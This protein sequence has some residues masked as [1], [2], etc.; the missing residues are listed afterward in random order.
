M[1]QALAQAYQSGLMYATFNKQNYPTATGLAIV[2]LSQPP[3][4]NSFVEVPNAGAYAR[5]AV[6][7]T[8]SEWSYPYGIGSGIVFNNNQKSFAIATAPWG[9]VSG[10]A[11]ADCVGYGGG[12]T[13][14]GS[15]LFYGTVP[16]PKDVGINDQIIISTS[17]LSV[18][19]Y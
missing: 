1:S 11:I 19:M 15:I 14:S 2:L 4:A 6:P 18:R 12:I 17:G 3:T 10:I 16:T 9:Y 7:Q 8:A 5:I 13:G